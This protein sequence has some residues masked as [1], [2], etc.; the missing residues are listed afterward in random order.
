MSD[1]YGRRMTLL[2]SPIPFIIGWT[3]FNYSNSLVLVYVAFLI[4]GLGSGLKEASSLTYTGE[5]W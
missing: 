1:S 5:V 3:M 2:L 4:L